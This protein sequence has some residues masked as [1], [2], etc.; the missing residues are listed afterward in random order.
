MFEWGGGCRI[1]FKVL[2]IREDRHYYYKVLVSHAVHCLKVYI[3]TTGKASEYVAQ[4]QIILNLRE[5]HNTS[6]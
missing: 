1:G 5:L 2:L 4:I 3:L 6:K